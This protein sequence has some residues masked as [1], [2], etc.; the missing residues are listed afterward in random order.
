MYQLFPDSPVDAGGGF[1]VP[2]FRRIREGLRASIQKVTEYRQTNTQAING[3]HLL[4]RLLQNVNISL[5]LPVEIYIDKVADIAYQLATALQLTSPLTPGRVHREGVCYRQTGGG[6][7]QVAVQEIFIID[8]TDFDVVD[9]A[10]RWR[11]YSPIRVLSHPFTD[12]NLQVPDGRHNFPGQ[13]MAVVSINVP[14]LAA[15]Y[16][17]WRLERK[18]IE[19][20]QSPRTIGQFLMEVP[21][22][23]MLHSHVDVVLMNR[24]IA[25]Y[26]NVPLSPDTRA[27]PFFLPD[28]SAAVDD[29]LTKYLAVCASR[30]YDFTGIL[31]HFPTVSNSNYL[32][33][34]RLPALAYTRQ[35]QWAIVLSRLTLTYFLVHSNSAWRNER[36]R[37][38]LNYL[39][40]YFQLMDYNR[41]LR[42]NLDSVSYRNAMILIED[43]IL[44]YL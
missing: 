29:V 10:L 27:H 28:Y 4:V 38:Y 44:P 39:R 3:S 22:P 37:A 40:R 43:G 14:M 32:E 34:I 30:R 19:E 2:E 31:A 36:N 41:T 26:F 1:S 6:N 35:I 33:V 18:D 16:R 24:M 17:H 7:D 13:G 15:Q 8:T 9:F 5:A 25:H 12:L 21:L 42:T 11:S 20:R 23:N